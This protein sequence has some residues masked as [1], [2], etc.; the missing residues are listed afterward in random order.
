MAQNQREKLARLSAKRGAYAQFAG[1]LDHGVGSHGVNSG[2]S[3]QQGD[4]SHDAGEQSH[5]SSLFAGR[6]HVVRHGLNV[7]DGEI[8]VERG[9]SLANERQK[10]LGAQI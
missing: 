7:V 10:S 3:K 9:N 6:F 2:A 1:A 8:L 5:K 4:A